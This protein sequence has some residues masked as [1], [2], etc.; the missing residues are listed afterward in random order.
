MAVEISI[1]SGVRQGQHIVLDGMKL[2]AG[3]D[4]AFEI[5]FDPQADSSARDRSVSLSLMDDGWYIQSTGRGEVFVNQSPVVGLTRLKSGSIVRM[6]EFG[7]E[8]EFRILARSAAAGERP[9]GAGLAAAGM[10]SPPG[11]SAQ[12]AAVPGEAAPPVLP[13]APYSAGPSGVSPAAPNLPASS[14][15]V[16]P[17]AAQEPA[18]PAGDAPRPADSGRLAVIVGGI[19]LGGLVL[20]MAF[21]VLSPPQVVVLPPSNSAVEKDH[22]VPDKNTNAPTEPIAPAPVVPPPSPAVPAVDPAMARAK[23]AVLLIQVEKSGQFL[24]FAACCA[25]SQN[26]VL[27]TAHE[28]VQLTI[29]RKDPRFGFKAWVTNPASGLKLAVQDIRVYGVWLKVEKPD[30]AI[31]TNL[32]LLTV[33]GTLPRP[34]ELAGPN[35]LAQLAQGNVLHVLGYT[36]EGDLVTPADHFEV[37][38]TAAKILLTAAHPELPLK[39]R[40]LGIKADVPSKSAYGSPIVNA[41]GKVVAIYSN[42]FAEAGE[43][44]KAR[45]PGAPNM[46][47]AT[48]VNPDV[49]NLGLS[50]SDNSVWVSTADLKIP[51]AEVKAPAKAA[52]AKTRKK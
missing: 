11:W 42:P 18:R 12:P 32:A 37:G 2:R 21:K 36:H 14:S 52:P 4:P 48:V 44:E 3:P 23:E 38:E 47:Y 10:G 50:K 24:P 20:V 35:E 39:P 51:D 49:L 1:L 34:A 46:H 8:F 22:A 5:Y 41:Q 13:A 27:T 33:E 40:R 31:F 17:V 7:P 16:A 43:D 15:P 28:A 19:I 9:S 6:S 30:D 45:S 26:T 25:L 29:W